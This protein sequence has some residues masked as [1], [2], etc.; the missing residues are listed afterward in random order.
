MDAEEARTTG[1]R[2]R[3]VRHARGKSLRVVAELAGMSRMTL[4]R[5]ERGERALD[6]RSEIAALANALKVAPSEL[7]RMSVPVPGNGETDTADE[8]V[9]LALLAVIHDQPRGQVCSA[10]ELRTRVS[11][12]LDA[13]CRRDQQAEA[14]AVLPDLIRDVHSSLEAGRDVAE[15]LELAVLLHTQGT[16]AWL[17]VVGAPLDLRSQAVGLARRAAQELDSPT[18]MGI[19]TVGSVGTLLAAGAFD[20]A[21]TTLDAV[22]V[23]TT[24][25]QRTQL[26]GMLALSQSLVAAA[27]NRPAD[28][29]ASLEC[30]DELAERTGEG[31]AYWMGFGPTNVGQWK[32][33]DALEI[34]DHERAVAIA[35]GLRPDGHPNVPRR[36]VYWVDYGRALARVRG[37]QDDAVR[38]FRRA[39]STSPLHLLRNQFARDTL[40]ELAT[41]RA[42][43]DVV[44]RELRGMAYRAGLPV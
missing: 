21:Q 28:I 22:T 4:L 16:G 42:R 24:N 19:A 26:A 38:A 27:E 36:A 43:R 32:M 5:I 23:P 1:R 8:A 30:A 14:G 34:G 10:E 44:G 9:R 3:Q 40:A 11:S 2:V 31:N 6:R 39:E 33:A 35:E 37:R 18:A 15:L 17:R 41:T 29:D 25:P 7:T 12:M 20:I 13:R